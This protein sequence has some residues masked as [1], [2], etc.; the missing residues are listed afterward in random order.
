LRK[1]CEKRQGS[2]VYNEGEAERAWSNP[3]ALYKAQLR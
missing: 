3:G 1:E 2:A